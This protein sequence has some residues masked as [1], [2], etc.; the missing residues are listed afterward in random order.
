MIGSYRE[1][2]KTGKY[3]SELTW[4]A[5]SD[6][7]VVLEKEADVCVKDIAGKQCE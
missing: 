6:V 1:R 5:G 4:N 3:A 7:T 2:L